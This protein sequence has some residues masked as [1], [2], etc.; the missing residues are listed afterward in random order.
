MTCRNEIDIYEIADE[1]LSAIPKHT[2]VAIGTHGFIKE[3]YKKA[4]CYCFLEK[5]INLLEPSG[6]IVYG[7]LSGNIFTE[8]E[9]KC[10]FYYYEPWIYT[11]RK[12][13]R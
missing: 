3:T 10:K 9:D 4:E 1:Y 5:I 2:L 11:N 7:N 6:I 13:K 12:K 8:F